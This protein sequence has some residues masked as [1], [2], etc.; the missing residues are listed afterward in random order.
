MG[1]PSCYEKMTMSYSYGAMNDVFGPAASPSKLKALVE[2]HYSIEL[3]WWPLNN[4]SLERF[5]PAA[6]DPY[7]D[8]LM[9]YLTERAAAP[10]GSLPATYN[11]KT[12][13]IANLETA[14]GYVATSVGMQTGNLAVQ[15][16]APRLVF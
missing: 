12:D 8:C 9:V 6:W 4:T 13:V 15:A 14:L 1:S 11:S 16:V 7:T 10:E 2:Q 5:S 3:F